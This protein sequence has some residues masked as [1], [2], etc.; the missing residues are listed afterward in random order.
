MVI[1]RKNRDPHRCVDYQQLNKH[2]TREMHHM[3]SPFH[4]A[5]LFPPGTKTVSDAWNRYH[6]IPIHEDDRHY[7]TF[8]TPWGWYRYKTLPQGFITASDRY[9]RWY[10]TSTRKPNASTCG[11]VGGHH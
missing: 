7:T 4:Q 3:I 6:A 8:I 9:T 10:L 5:T 11:D 2:C 1:S